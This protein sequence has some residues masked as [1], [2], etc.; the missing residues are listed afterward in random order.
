MYRYLAVLTICS[1][2]GLQTWN[3]LFNNFAVEV[4]GLRGDGVGAVQSIRE[5]PGFLALLAVFVM[6]VLREHRLAALAIVSLGAGLAA[7]GFFPSFAGIAVTTLVSSFGFHYY[8]TANQSL[9]LQYF[10]PEVSPRVFGRLSSL[11]A[12]TSIAVAL[13]VFG[14]ANLLDYSS[15]YLAV[16]AAIAMV[17]LA[18]L[19]RDPTDG[20][21]APQ[22]RRMVFR[23][24]Y[25]LFYLLTFLAGAR[26][27]IF[28]AFSV[29]LL[30]QKFGFSVREIALLFVVNNAINYFLAPLIGRAILRFGERRVLTVEYVSVILIFFGYSQV[31]ARPVAAVLF[32]LDQVFFTFAMAIRT[33]LQK[34][35]DPQDIAPSSAVGFTI[36]HIAAVVLPVAGGLLWMVDYRIPFWG[37]MGLGVLSLA[38]VRRIRC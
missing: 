37:G 21:V 14:L 23:R 34:V 31:A 19:L 32:V 9:T 35:A 13:A 8:E 15:I 36:N 16:G 12:G 1:T 3:T 10:P 38:F 18:S 28:T 22:R 2:A 5:V 26:R 24:K 30:V 27:Q 29:L 11:A 17:G 25:G 6:L 4:G 7:T 20:K 33:Y